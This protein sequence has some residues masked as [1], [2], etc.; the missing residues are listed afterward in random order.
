M[1]SASLRMPAAPPIHYAIGNARWLG[2]EVDVVTAQSLGNSGIAR[3][4]FLQNLLDCA[5]WEAEA[6]EVGRLSSALAGRA[7]PGGAAGPQR[8]H[9]ASAGA[10]TGTQ[11]LM[12]CC[13]MLLFL[14]TY[15]LEEV[16]KQRQWWEMSWRFFRVWMLWWRRRKTEL[17]EW[18]S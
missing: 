15:C 18:C 11:Q 7:S 13:E 17:N 14:W 10:T 2:L 16:G 9:G 12:L 5:L 4:G 8:G 6:A 1:P 3:L